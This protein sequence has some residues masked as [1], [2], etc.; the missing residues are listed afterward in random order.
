[1]D[2]LRQKMKMIKDLGVQLGG[3]HFHCGSGQN[4]AKNFDEAIE[5]ARECIK[6][7]RQ[8]GHSMEIIDIGGGL[9]AGE[10]DSEL[11]ET[12][13]STKNDPL[14][15]QIISEPGRYLSSRSCLL[16][17]R[18]IGKREK[19]NRKC[20]HINDSLYHSFNCVLMDG[21]SFEDQSDQ[22]YS[23]FNHNDQSELGQLKNGSMFG[24]TCDGYDV[25]VKNLMMPELNVGD[26]LI[27]GGMGAYTYGPRS[28]FNGMTT[29]DSIY[30]HL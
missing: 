18:V 3:I 21:V 22:F 20:Y 25:I 4:G 19:Q 8:V 9:P 5:L 28:N 17:T 26:W 14:G 27:M 15:Y 2:K 10:L 7:G 11:L 30:T 23:R 12:L 16:A 1:M 13:R 6:I 29:L 24:M